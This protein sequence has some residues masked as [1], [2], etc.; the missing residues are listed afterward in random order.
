MT[1][2]VCGYAHVNLHP[3]VYVHM[4]VFLY[5]QVDAHVCE[6]NDM[7]STCS[8]VMCQVLSHVLMHGA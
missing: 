2:C 7:C 8:C 6:V 5:A 1:T 4:F 3:G